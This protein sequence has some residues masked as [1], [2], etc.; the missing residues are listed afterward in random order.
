VLPAE[1]GVTEQD[2]EDQRSVHT[3][4]D[5]KR[6]TRA[7]LA[8][9]IRDRRIPRLTLGQPGGN[10]QLVLGGLWALIRGVTSI[11][12]AFMVPHAGRSVAAA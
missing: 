8:P 10:V 1:V 3:P 2:R 6:H 7:H 4:P 12:L 11:V 5:Q 9:G